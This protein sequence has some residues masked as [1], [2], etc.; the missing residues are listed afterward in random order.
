MRNPLPKKAQIIAVTTPY[1]LRFVNVRAF[2]ILIKH[3]NCYEAMPPENCNAQRQQLAHTGLSVLR[4]AGS[5]IEAK[6]AAFSNKPNRPVLTH[7]G[8]SESRRYVG[9]MDV[10]G[11]LVWEN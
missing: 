9:C 1:P 3:P 4:P 5:V 2:R 6:A 11:Q 7:D 10:S 8:I